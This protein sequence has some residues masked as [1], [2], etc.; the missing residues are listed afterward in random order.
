MPRLRTLFAPLIAGLALAGCGGSGGGSSSRPQGDEGAVYD[1]VLA[2][3][4]TPDCDGIT[5]RALA[6]LATIGSTRAQRC[7]IARS[8]PYP[9][10]SAVK[11]QNIAVNG[12][13]ATAQV[14]ATGVTSG[15]HPLVEHL[16]LVKQ[17]GR[18]LIDG[19]DLR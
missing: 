1:A 15:G 5:D 6:R 14:P 13:A 17:G 8:R 10:A 11:I 18:W 7:K 3:E 19:V 9:P 12:A 16:A 4:T 2:F